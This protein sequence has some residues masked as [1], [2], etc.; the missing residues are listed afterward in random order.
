MA[1]LV[2][3]PHELFHTNGLGDVI[4]HLESTVAPGKDKVRA[5]KRWGAWVGVGLSAGDLARVER[6]GLESAP[7][8]RLP[9]EKT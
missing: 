8:F 3:I 4:R 6:T 1:A 7:T 2:D 9:G 5:L